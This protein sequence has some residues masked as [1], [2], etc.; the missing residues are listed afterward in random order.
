MLASAARRPAG[1]H[2]GEDYLAVALNHDSSGFVAADVIDVEQSPTGR[3]VARPEG[4]VPA[5]A[6]GLAMTQNFAPVAGA[7]GVGLAA[8]GGVAYLRLRRRRADGAA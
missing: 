8:A 2:P 5:G 3:D 6:G 7:A 4:A 1:R